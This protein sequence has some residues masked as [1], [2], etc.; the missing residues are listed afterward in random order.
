MSRIA[1]QRALSSFTTDFG[2]RSRVNTPF[3]LPSTRNTPLVVWKSAKV[4]DLLTNDG[5]DAVEDTVVHL[6]RRLL[7]AVM[8][9][10]VRSHGPVPPHSP[11][12]RD[13]CRP[14]RVP[15]LRPNWRR[16]AGRQ[17]RRRQRRAPPPTPVRWG[18]ASAGHTHHR[19]MKRS[20]VALTSRGPCRRGAGCREGRPARTDTCPPCRD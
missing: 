1:V 13:S 10:P 6:N 12:A 14:G 15:R 5:G 4:P 2:R 20:A 16:D 8:G 7:R 3:L 9:T 19:H 11:L 17:R 18:L